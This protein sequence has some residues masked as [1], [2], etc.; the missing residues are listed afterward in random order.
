MQ[1]DLH[2][3]EF[4]AENLFDGCIIFRFARFLYNIHIHTSHID[5]KHLFQGM[6]P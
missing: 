6:Y 4:V 3:V 5:M 2:N 1:F